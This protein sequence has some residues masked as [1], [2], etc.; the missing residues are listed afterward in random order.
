MIL[1]HCPSRAH[2]RQDVRGLNKVE[3]V[4]NAFG[5]QPDARAIMTQRSPGRLPAA[6]EKLVLAVG[7]TGATVGKAKALWPTVV[8][9]RA[10]K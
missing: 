3:G 5:A 6:G 2:A 10:N 1:C 4:R 7:L 8:T 9:E